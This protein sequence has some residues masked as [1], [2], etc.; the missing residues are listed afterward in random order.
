MM[1]LL[2]CG[3]F[4][5]MGETGFYSRFLAKECHNGTNFVRITFAAVLKQDGGECRGG[6]GGVRICSVRER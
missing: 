5:V 4:L 2:L 3:T 1:G 6:R